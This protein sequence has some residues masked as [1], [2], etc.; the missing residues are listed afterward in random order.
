MQV[1]EHCCIL[2]VQECINGGKL[3]PSL[4]C[5]YLV[6]FSHDGFLDSP[7]FHTTEPSLPAQKKKIRQLTLSGRLFQ[8]LFLVTTSLIGEIY[9]RCS[10]QNDQL[11]WCSS[12]YPSM[13]HAGNGVLQWAHTRGFLLE[14]CKGFIQLGG[15]QRSFLIFS[16]ARRAYSHDGF[17]YNPLFPHNQA[18]TSPSQYIYI[19]IN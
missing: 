6:L 7:Y 2:N 18:I 15:I 1:L 17:L 11:L 14:T 13:F 19:Y 10:V 16:S 12:G 3:E 5:L 9:Y 8:Q 4:A